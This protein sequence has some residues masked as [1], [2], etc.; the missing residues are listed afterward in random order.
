MG[1]RGVWACLRAYSQPQKEAQPWVLTVYSFTFHHMSMWFIH[2]WITQRYHWEHNYQMILQL[3]DGWLGCVDLFAPTLTDSTECR[4]GVLG[5][6]RSVFIIVNFLLCLLQTNLLKIYFPTCCAAC[7]STLVIE[8]Y[9]IIFS[10]WLMG[11]FFPPLLH[12]TAPLLG[13]ACLR[14]K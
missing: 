7:E 8:F 12:S 11:I 4:L 5:I 6:L 9:I 3:R 14:R 1:P 2:F 13:M 10:L